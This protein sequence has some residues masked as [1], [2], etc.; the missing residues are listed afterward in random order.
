MTPVAAQAEMR[1]VI[2][3]W[4]DRNDVR[5]LP[6]TGAASVTFAGLPVATK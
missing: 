1:V 5:R 6:P 2:A 4:V 3:G